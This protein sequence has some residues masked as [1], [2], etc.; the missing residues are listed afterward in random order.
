MYIC[1]IINEHRN[2]KEL[3]WELNNYNYKQEKCRQE[4]NFQWKKKVKANLYYGHGILIKTDWLTLTDFKC[5][6]EKLI[7]KTSSF[8][9]S[10]MTHC[11][12]ENN[13]LY[14]WNYAKHHITNLSCIYEII[15]PCLN[16]KIMILNSTQIV[17]ISS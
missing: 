11:E 4:I 14:Y 10:M 13:K 2:F 8:L 5:F 16:F 12:S 7:V 15:Q 3:S 9:A 17:T 6:N 1:K